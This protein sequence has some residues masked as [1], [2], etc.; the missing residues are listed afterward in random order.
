ML[1]RTQDDKGRVIW[2]FFGNSIHDPEQTFWKSFFSDPDAE[3]PFTDSISFFTDLIS[4]A[5]G[6]KLSDENT[7]FK[8]GFRIMTSVGSVLPKW[9]ERFLVSDNTLSPDIKYLLTFRPFQNLPE[10]I[11]LQYLAGKLN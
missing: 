10:N 3:I 5:Y 9:T 11:R 2:T 4:A 6:E 1:S 7:L 8:S